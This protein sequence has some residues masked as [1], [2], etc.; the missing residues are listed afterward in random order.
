MSNDIRGLEQWDGQTRA[1][2]KM[3]GKLKT[4]AGIGMIDALEKWY[5]EWQTKPTPRNI[6]ETL[7][8]RLRLHLRHNNDPE[9]LEDLNE[10]FEIGLY[11]EK[12]G[13]TYWKIAP[14]T[15]VQHRKGFNWRTD[16]GNAI[17]GGSDPV[18]DEDLLE[19]LEE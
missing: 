9:F 14:E 16:S 19:D 7:L 18:V 13:P 17:R 11:D 2:N 15:N 4:R 8:W 12:V 5:A 6:R 3:A 10:Y 1:W